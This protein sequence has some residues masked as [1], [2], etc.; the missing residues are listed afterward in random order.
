MKKNGISVVVPV[1][2]E[3]NTIA[4]VLKNLI[5]ID[6]VNEIVVIDD[7]SADKT[8]NEIKKVISSK[9]ILIENSENL[10]KGATVRQSFPHLLSEYSVIQDADLELDPAYIKEYFKLATKNDLDVVFGSR[11][12]NF[13]IDGYPF[14]LSLANKIY[15]ELINYLTS[16]KYSDVNCGHKFFKTNELLKIDFKENHFGAD[17]EISYIVAHKKLAFSE[18]KINFTARNKSQGKKITWLD[19]LKFFKIIFNVHRRFKSF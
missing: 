19:G 16:S 4:L 3:E 12:K 1:F 14:S 11:F 13:R 2:N 6:E 9:I 18:Y 8:V 15:T 7:N 10:G 5:K 17:P